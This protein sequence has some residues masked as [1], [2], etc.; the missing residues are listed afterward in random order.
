MR[1][2][3]SHLAYSNAKIITIDFISSFVLYCQMRR[4]PNANSEHHSVQA[5]FKNVRFLE[6]VRITKLI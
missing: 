5:M 4:R 3:C 6:T 1:H 2:E